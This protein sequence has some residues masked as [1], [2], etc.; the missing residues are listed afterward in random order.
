MLHGVIALTQVGVVVVVGGWWLWGCTPWV[1]LGR[2]ARI[3]HVVVVVVGH[4]R[5][6]D[7]HTCG[8]VSGR[9]AAPAAHDNLV[10]VLSVEIVARALATAVFVTFATTHQRTAKAALCVAGGSVTCRRDS[11]TSLGCVAHGL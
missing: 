9:C 7:A 6:Y 1:V 5:W 11:A 8:C 4:A 2:F 10:D 3:G